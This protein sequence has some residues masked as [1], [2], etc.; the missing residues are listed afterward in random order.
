M[1]HYAR[2][3]THYLSKLKDILE[4]EL[5]SKGLMDLALEDFNLVS[6]TEPHLPE[7][8]EITCWKA[9]GAA[10][11]TPRQAAILQ[12]LCHYRDQQARKFDLPHFKVLSND[13]LLELCL[14]APHSSEELA[15]VPGLSARLR[16]RHATGLLAAIEKGE[17]VLPVTRP[18][19]PQV[20]P[21]F[22]KRLDNLKKWRKAQAARLEV[23]SDVVL[24]REIM[25]RIA[26]ASPRELTELQKLMAE[27]PWRYNQ[28]GN[29]ILE[30]IHK[31]E[32]K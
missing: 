17:T 19:R 13:L 14:E 2:M 22:L 30:V 11:I 3:D 28:Y 18:P 25:E 12:E 23:E 15:A 29:V 24:P 6:H 5:R 16:Q 10:R 4:G 7:N 21:L 26:S 32:S 27:I 9:A 8:N 31:G 20:D 1:Q